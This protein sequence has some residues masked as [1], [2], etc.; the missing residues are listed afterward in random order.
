[1]RGMK[2]LRVKRN[3][4]C[5]SRGLGRF[6]VLCYVVALGVPHFSHFPL[7]ILGL[8]GL[9]S[10]Y[11]KSG[12]GAQLLKYINGPL[13]VVVCSTLLSILFATDIRQSI[14][15]SSSL[16]ACAVLFY[17]IISNFD[18][19]KLRLLFT[20]IVLVNIVVASVLTVIVCRYPGLQPAEWM[21]KAD[22]P[23]LSVPND[24]LLLSSCAPLTLAL[25]CLEKRKINRFIALFSLLM[26]LSIVIFFQ[27]KSALLV[28][29]LSIAFCILLLRPK[30]FQY[31]ILMF[32]VTVLVV[33]GINNFLLYKKT[34]DFNLWTIRF[35]LWIAAGKMFLDAPLLGQGPGSFALL[36]DRYI[37]ELSLPSWVVRDER[38]MPWAHSLYLEVLAER[39][40]IGL[41]A[42][43]SLFVGI[44]YALWF[45]NKS[46]KEK[47]KIYLAVGLLS[48]L[49]AIVIGGVFELSILRHWVLVVMTVI[50]ASASILVSDIKATET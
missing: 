26:T 10:G 42:V 43:L 47:K 44:G 24:L 19:S 17:C 39:G 6:G 9:V 18:V 49:F 5:W 36:S 30:H 22:F 35:P 28:F 25:F 4:S 23:I 27:S 3:V 29:I 41:F 11:D 48:S 8:A 33:D 32:F 31:A 2:W 50:A 37:S 34:V 40:L 1:M 15:V 12:S 46:A 45:V 20:T 16:V 21:N 7:V 38:H 14:W 13:I